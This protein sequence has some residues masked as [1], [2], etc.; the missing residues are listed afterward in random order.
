MFTVGAI[1]LVFFISKAANKG[2]DVDR[3]NYDYMTSPDDRLWLLALHTRQDLKLVAFLL[4]GV[5]FVLGVVA[6]RLH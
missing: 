2:N 1:V 4:M 3:K 5:I 6:D